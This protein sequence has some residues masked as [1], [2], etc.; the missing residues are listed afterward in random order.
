MYRRST[1]LFL[2]LVFCTMI[3]G[4]FGGGLRPGS[5]EHHK[6]FLGKLK[7]EYDHLSVEE[8]V[9]RLRLLAPHI[10]MNKDGFISSK[11]LQIWVRDKY[12]S[13]LDSEDIDFKFRELDI[14]FDNSLTWDEYTERY[15]GLNNTASDGLSKEIKENFKEYLARDQRRWKYA[16]IDEDG[17]LNLEEFHMFSKPTKYAEMV[18]V[19]AYEEIEHYDIN[20]DGFLSLEEYLKAIAMP[21]MRPLDEKKFHEE[22]DLDKDGRLNKDEVKLW[23][24]PKFFDQAELEAK[25]LIRIADDDQDGKLTVKEIVHNHFV[26]VGSK[27]T[28]SG[29]MLHDEF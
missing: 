12:T 18:D 29:T 2:P 17:A 6:A 5:D 4:I 13:I 9:R 7:D 1:V 20:K 10:D 15:Y 26:F 8:S 19:V 11:E 28:I 16:D 25:E 22:Y 3:G 27:A 24:T 14:H 21:A 23:K